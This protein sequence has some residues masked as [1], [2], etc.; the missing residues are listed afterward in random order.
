[1]QLKENIAIIGSGISGLTCAYVLDRH[2]KITLFEA[3][4]Y[5]GGHTN[6]VMVPYKDEHL[7]IDT[8]FIVF[9]QSNYPLF[10][11]LV[12]QINV[13]YQN[14]E[15]SFSFSSKKDQL[16]YSGRKLSTL[17]SQKRNWVRPQFYRLLNDILRF[18]RDAKEHLD[19]AI[20]SSVSLKSFVAA[21]NYS[22]WFWEVYLMPMVAAI[23]SST[24]NAVESM[25][26]HRVLS[27]FDNHGLLQLKNAPQWL[28]IQGGSQ[29][30]VK[31]LLKNFSGIAVKNAYVSKVSRNEAGVTLHF[32]DEQQHFDQV[33]F[34]CHSDTALKL[35]ETPT[36]HE[37]NIL[38]AIPYQNNE[39]ILHTDH[40][41]MPERKAV[42][43]SWN[44]HARDLGL[45]ALTYYMN[46]LQGLTIPQDYFVSLNVTA[47]L[48][49]KHI[50]A[51]FNYSHPVLDETAIQAQS[52]FSKISGE[53]NTFYCGAYWFNGFHED[54]V[55]SGVRVC[56]Q[57]G[58]SF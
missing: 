55:A 41:I 35:L 8:G 15:M 4:G 5:F 44:Y 30:Y 2:C 57:L 22:Q 19:N 3:N 42:W 28:T 39:V 20:N 23:W 33:I 14:T 29:T 18:N 43:S 9:N 6:T 32:G 36:D 38:K 40:S 31:A 54:G 45:T 25:S 17:F 16:E 13:D 21:K 50:I 34:A 37:V 10:T 51:Q 26:A 56:N 52:E 24:P 49:P 46:R 58:V 47:E 48:Q 53:N 12:Q 1:L 11:K 7:A 27:F